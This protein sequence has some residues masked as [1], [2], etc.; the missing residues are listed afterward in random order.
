MAKLTFKGAEIET[1]GELPAV[2]EQARALKLWSTDLSYK[3]LEDFGDKWKVLNIFPS[4]DTAVCA[5]SVRRFHEALADKDNVATLAIAADLPFAFK[6]FCG[7][8]GID[9]V[10]ALSTFN[11][12]FG[13]TWGLVM[14]GGPLSGLLA[15]AVVV[16]DPSNK[17]VHTQLV[18]EVTDEAN[19][20]AAI[21]ALG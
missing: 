2:G 17:I 12:D 19:Y 9:S 20:D 6:R 3:T 13:E 15:R 4:I 14:K 16:L 7:A 8:E 18:P 5:I 10:A 1:S 11:S 21:A